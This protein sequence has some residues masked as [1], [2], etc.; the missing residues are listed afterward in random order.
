ML[1]ELLVAFAIVAVCVVLHVASIVY[2]ADWMLD[3]REKRKELM[4]ELLRGMEDRFFEV[5]AVA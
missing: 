1:K 2:L 5:I 4:G 3:Q